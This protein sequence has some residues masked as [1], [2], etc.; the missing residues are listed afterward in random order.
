MT[1][2]RTIRTA[3]ENRIIELVAALE[4]YSRQPTADVEWLVTP[5]YRGAPSHR[6]LLVVGYADASELDSDGIQPG[7]DPSIDAWSISCGVATTDVVEA[8][9]AK[10]LC[11]A[12]FNDVADLLARLPDLSMPGGP[13]DLRAIAPAG[14]PF[15]DWLPSNPNNPASELVPTGWMNFEIPCFADIE[16]NPS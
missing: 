5:P 14:G 8:Q 1:S 13:R 12:A 10:A 7:A 2:P 15:F 11:E 16:R 9:E 3:T 6:R 4:G